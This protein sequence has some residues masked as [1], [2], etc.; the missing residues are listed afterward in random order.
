MIKTD[1]IDFPIFNVADCFITC[2]CIALVVS[3][4]FNR[5]FWK[6]EKKREDTEETE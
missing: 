6:D 3:L 1:F 5:D 4:L 2:G